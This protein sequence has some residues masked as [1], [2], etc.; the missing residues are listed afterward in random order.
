M[1]QLNPMNEGNESV[2]IDE[3]KKLSEDVINS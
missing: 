2:I 3:E 1:V